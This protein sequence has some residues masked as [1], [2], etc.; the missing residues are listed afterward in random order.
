KAGI[1]QQNKERE[2]LEL[3]ENLKFELQENG[4]EILAVPD[5]EFRITVMVDYDSPVLGTQ[6]ASMY[7]INEFKDE[8]SSCRTFVFLGELE[9]LAKNGL[10]KGGDLDN[11]IVLVEK[12]VTKDYLKYLADLL[13]RDEDLEAVNVKGIGLLNNSELKYRNEPARH[14]LLDIIGDLALLGKP[15]KGHLLAA[16]PGHLGNIEFTKE[17]IK[18]FEKKEKEPIKIDFNKDPVY[19]TND[20]MNILPHRPPFLFID[21]ILDINDNGIT[22]IKNVTMN[23]PFFPGHFPENPI[24]PGVIQIEAMAQVGGVFALNTVPDPEHYSTYFMKIDNVKFKRKV[25]PGDTIA[26]KLKLLTPIRRGI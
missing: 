5:D 14:K 2:Y 21:K 26:F 4:I 19:S 10:I 18:H 12:D 3:D 7:N 11:A 1:V 15:I 23:E 13:G 22:G 17:I 8:F 24:M 20:L 25:V 9:T 6:H 16:R